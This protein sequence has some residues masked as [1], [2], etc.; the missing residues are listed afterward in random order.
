MKRIATRWLGAST[1]CLSF[2]I[3]Q[4]QSCSSDDSG[5][6]AK[7]GSAAPQQQ[8]ITSE[9]IE[10][11]RLGREDH[12]RVVHTVV[13]PISSEGLGLTG[14]QSAD[15]LQWT[16]DLEDRTEVET[17][18]AP[19]KYLR[20]KSNLELPKVPAGEEYQIGCLDVELRDNVNYREPTWLRVATT[21]IRGGKYTEVVLP[22]ALQVDGW[23]GVPILEDSLTLG[24]FGENSIKKF[25]GK[26]CFKLDY[27]GAPAQTYNGQIVVQYLKPGTQVDCASETCE[28]PNLPDPNEFQCSDEPKVIK[29]G[30]I[31]QFHWSLPSDDSVI[32]VT[33]SDADSSLTGAGQILGSFEPVGRNQ[34]TYYAPAKVP[35][36]R[37]VLLNASLAGA[38]RMP[39]FCE[40]TLI[41]DQDIGAEDDGETAGLVGNVYKL[42]KNTATLPDFSTMESVASIM[43]GN[44]EIPTRSFS[45][46]F[47]GVADLFEWFGIQFKGRL[48]IAQS[49][50]YDFQINSDDGANLYINGSKIVDNDGIHSPRKREGS[51]YLAEGMHDFTVDYY[52]G[53]RVLIAL[54]LFWRVSGAEQE[55]VIIPAGSF[56]RPAE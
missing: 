29:A 10:Q 32:H 52:Q 31:A 27:E 5:F 6:N 47:P 30:Q 15:A 55:F 22:L 48:Y 3:A 35:T 16:V 7:S 13:V 42:P 12:E 23:Q 26:L 51:V 45:S 24:R 25:D 28:E 44:L 40:L 11:V 19:V 34:V 43:V 36:T 53:P 18:V 49:G 2:G 9:N 17:E 21:G 41:A 54:E 14:D 1:V 4:L 50:N 20:V 33:L 39:V 37:K 56:R 46:G 38:D 8:S